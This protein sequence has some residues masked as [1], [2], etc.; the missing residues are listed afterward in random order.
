[1][2][3][4]EGKNENCEFHFFSFFLGHSHESRFLAAVVFPPTGF[5]RGYTRFR[6]I[7]IVYAE[8]T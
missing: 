8:K 3:K 4:K 5:R 7:K 1:M 6:K 2:L